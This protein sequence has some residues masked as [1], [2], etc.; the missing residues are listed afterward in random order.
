MNQRTRLRSFLTRLS[1]TVGT[2]LAVPVV[3]AAQGLFS[4]VATVNDR[5]V[6]E[7]EVQQRQAFLTVLNSPE[8]SREF[9]IEAL[10][11][12]RLRAD[13]VEN[14]G[15]ELTPE[16]LESGLQ[17]F[18]GRANLEY[19]AFVTALSEAGVAEETIIDFVTVGVSWRN[20]INARYGRRLEVSEAEID[21]ALGGAS[22]STGIRVLVSEII[23]PA[24][25]ERLDDVRALAEEIAQTTSVDQFSAYA[26]EYSASQTRQ[27]G[28]QVPWQPIGNLPPVLRPLLLSLA[29]GE[30]T[31][32]L[33]IPNAVALFQLRAIEETSAPAP[34]YA[35]I[36]YAMY[37]IPGGRSAAALARAEKVRAEI[38]VCNDLYGVAQDQPPEVL[39]RITQ[40]PGEIPND[41][42]IELS[43]L[44][45]GEVSTTLTRN[46]GDTLVFLMM[47]GR[48]EVANAEADRAE[49][50]RA[51]RASRLNAVAESLLA[52]LRANAR[53]TYQ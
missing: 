21:R 8:T 27:A 23:I 40:A 5:L 49:V 18:A 1:L 52:Q 12:E 42:A 9:V 16:A 48:T 34:Q 7:Y 50:A 22:A 15:L 17:E 20:F 39:E 41:I 4:P 33:T 24:P 38:D 29:P 37:Y 28:G 43:K 14:A 11:D 19:D 47:C 26:R 10:I 51:L 53:I 32:P 36:D 31:D 13:A 35:A 3:V 2:M 45:R 25:P 46:G 30:V 6:T 44:D